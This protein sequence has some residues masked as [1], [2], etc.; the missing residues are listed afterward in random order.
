M[1]RVVQAV[2]LL[3]D[4]QGRVVAV[5][6]RDTTV[7]GQPARRVLGR[8]APELF[9]PASADKVADLLAAPDGGLVPAL[10]A[11]TAESGPA[12]S[13][14]VRA[15]PLLAEDPSGPVLELLIGTGPREWLLERTPLGLWCADLV[16]GVNQRDESAAALYGVSGAGALTT[17]EFLTRVHPDD[18]PD[19]LSLQ[20][21]A[22]EHPGR[23]VQAHFRFQGE[24]GGWRWLLTWACSFT[25]LGR[26]LLVGVSAALD[27]GP[28]GGA[29]DE[30]HRIARRVRRPA[31]ELLLA[32]SQERV[33]ELL[34]E[35]F[36]ALIGATQA[37]VGLLEGTRRLRIERR[38]EPPS[39]HDAPWVVPLDAALPLAVVARTGRPTYLSREQYLALAP[40]GGT[41][42]AEP[43]TRSW[44]ILPLTDPGGAPIGAWALGHDGPDGLATTA[45]AAVREV[46][47]LAGQALARTGRTQPYL[48][49]AGAFQAG[50]A[51]LPPDAVDGLAVTVRHQPSQDALGLGGDWYDLIDL[52]DGTVMVCVGDVQGHGANAAPLMAR[53]RTLVRAY[54][55][56]S[57]D[58][59]EVLGLVNEFLDRFPVTATAT[60]TLL[61]LDPRTGAALVARAAHPP[62]LVAGPDGSVRAESI[63]GGIPLGV[64]PGQSYPAVPVDLPPGALL[65]LCTDGLVEG[66]DLPLEEGLAR[67]GGLLAAWPGEDLEQLADRLL[68]LAAQ[69]GHQD[70]ATVLLVARQ[71]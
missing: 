31:E 26:P 70:D 56:G 44:S 59:G 58:P 5:C 30:G 43:R 9:G 29:S 52:R 27:G 63:A 32:P 67:L 22:A 62:L 24:D 64:L 60:C 2:S 42:V 23:V 55:L 18:V 17:T 34:L 71:P 33:A 28:V 47:R 61:R 20:L 16:A 12:Q 25:V 51:Q 35:R 53:L 68:P 36:P 19:L 15:R 39:G 21:D 48:D 37:T 49:L 50:A 66:P 6:P 65:A 41:L 46:A 14:W 38:P 69:T 4:R 57:P 7:G 1:D 10:L 8:P 45:V 13:V 3:V 11:T 54:A 40:T